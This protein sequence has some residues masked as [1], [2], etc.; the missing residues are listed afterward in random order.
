MYISFSLFFAIIII[1]CVFLF[2]DLQRNKKKKK[3]LFSKRRH[4]I[5]E[6]EKK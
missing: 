2:L 5:G 3:N 6:L 1:V 4:V